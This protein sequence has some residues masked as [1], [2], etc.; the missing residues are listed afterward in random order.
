MKIQH[1]SIV[2]PVILHLKILDSEV[3]NTTANVL[4]GGKVNRFQEQNWKN[5]KNETTI[6]LKVWTKKMNTKIEHNFCL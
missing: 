2:D 3:T 1:S 5:Q 4:R 6:K